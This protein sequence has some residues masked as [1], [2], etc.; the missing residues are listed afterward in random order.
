[1]RS[2]SVSPIPP[3]FAFLSVRG[4]APVTTPGS[5]A[6]PDRHP[7][8]TAQTIVT[9]RGDD[10]APRCHS[11]KDHKPLQ[12]TLEGGPTQQLPTLTL[13][14]L[15]P[16]TPRNLCAGGASP[17]PETKCRASSLY[18]W[19]SVMTRKQNLRTSNR[20]VGDANST[21]GSKSGE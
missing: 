9:A 8:T 20:C 16:L 2:G 19:G 15:R 14:P 13:E 3:S 18:T 1:M 17:R 4:A 11:H 12:L 6:A 5:A 7:G 10:P 21:P